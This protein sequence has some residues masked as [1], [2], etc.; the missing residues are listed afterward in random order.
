MDHS[1]LNKLASVT[2]ISHLHICRLFHLSN[3]SVCFTLKHKKKMKIHFITRASFP[4][5]AAAR[6]PCGRLLIG[7]TSQSIQCKI[8]RFY[9]FFCSD[10]A[11]LSHV[12][13][14]TDGALQKFGTAFY[15]LIGILHFFRIKNAIS[16]KKHLLYQ[17]LSTVCLEANECLATTA[18]LEGKVAPSKRAQQRGYWKRGYFR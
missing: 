2:F 7:Q 15:S 17:S 1:Y 4:K 9:F 18:A 6:V 16:S 14:G 8:Y 5:T 11:T 13:T 12:Y 10:I 3:N